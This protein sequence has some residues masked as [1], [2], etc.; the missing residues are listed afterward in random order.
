[1]KIDG[2]TTA[3]N[4]W[5]GDDTKPAS[6]MLVT[7]NSVTY[8]ILSSTVITGGHRVT[9]SRPDPNNRSTNLGL[10]GAVDDD[11]SVEFYLRSQIASSGHTMEYVGSGWKGIA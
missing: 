2:V 11:A 3:G 10:N 7:V 8:P 6:N 4:G 5:F 1:M 9:V